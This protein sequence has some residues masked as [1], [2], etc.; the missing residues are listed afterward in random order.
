MHSENQIEIRQETVEYEHLEN[1]NVSEDVRNGKT[2]R[3]H[4]KLLGVQIL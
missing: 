2:G 3:N 1:F 4:K